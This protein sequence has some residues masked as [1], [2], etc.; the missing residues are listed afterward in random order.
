MSTASQAGFA[1]SEASGMSKTT[2]QDFPQ[3]P[4]DDVHAHAATVYI[5]GVEARWAARGLLV[6]ANGGTPAAAKAIVDIDLSE[7]PELPAGH[8]D[9][10]RRIETRIKIKTQNH[11]NAEKR[12]QVVLDAWTALYTDLKISTE[13]NAPVLSRELKDTCDLTSVG[14]DGSFDGPRAWRI[15]K[16]YLAGAS[17]TETDKDFY[18]TAERIQRSS[19]LPDG[20]TAADYSKK[21]LAFLIHILPNL[22]QSYDKDDTTTYLVN[23]MPKTLREGGRRIKNE[24]KA[25]KR[26]HDFMYVIRKCH[27]LVHEEQKTASAAPAFVITDLDAVHDL[28][29]LSSTTGMFLSLTPALAA[30]QGFQAAGSARGLGGPAGKKW[31]PDC[32]HGANGTCF[33]APGYEGPLP[34]NVFLNKE[35]LAGIV[36]AK[37][38]NARESGETLKPLRDPSR[39]AIDDFKKRRNERREAAKARDQAKKDKDKPALPALPAPAGAAVSGDEFADWRASLLDISENAELVGVD[40]DATGLLD[41]ADFDGVFMMAGTD[42]GDE[43]LADIDDDEDDGTPQFWFVLMPLAD[44]CVPCIV[45]LTD[46]SHVERDHDMTA[47]SPVAFGSDEAMARKVFALAARGEPPA[48]APALPVTA[49]VVPTRDVALGGSTGA[50]ARA[51]ILG[52]PLGPTP[53]P[54]GS[55]GPASTAS[56]VSTA[57]SVAPTVS[58]LATASARPPASPLP[59]GAPGAVTTPA[60]VAPA[61]PATSPRPPPPSG[62]PPPPTAAAGSHGLCGSCT[63][64]ADGYSPFSALG[65]RARRTVEDAPVDDSPRPAALHVGTSLA[66]FFG[67]LALCLTLRLGCNVDMSACAGLATGLA[68]AVGHDYAAEHGWWDGLTADALAESALAVAARAARGFASFSAHAW[69]VGVPHVLQHSRQ[70]LVLVIVVLFLRGIRGSAQGGVSTRSTRIRSAAIAPCR[71]SLVGPCPSPPPS[72]PQ[73]RLPTSADQLKPP[74]QDYL[75]HAQAEQLRVEL[76]A[77][78]E[79]PPNLPRSITHTIAI[80][81]TGCARSMANHKDQ[82]K[83]GSI[84]SFESEVTGVAGALKTKERGHMAFP[85]LTHNKGMRVWNEKQSIL[86]EVCAYVLLSLGRASLEQGMDLVM[87]AWGKDCT[88]SWPNG[89]IV[90]LLNR[91]V[92]V[93]RPLGYKESPSKGLTACFS[94]DALAVPD[95]Q[96]FCIYLGSGPRRHDD[97]TNQCLHLEAPVEMVLWDPIID[98]SHDATKVEFKDAALASIASSERRRCRGIIVSTRCHTWSVAGFLPDAHGNPGKPWRD[99]DHFFGIPRDGAIPQVV[100]DANNESSHAAEICLAVAEQGGFVIVESPARRT[101][102]KAHPGHVLADCS[103][104]VHMFDHPAWKRFI[105]RTD[106]TELLWDQCTKAAIPSESAVKSTLWLCTPDMVQFLEAEFGKV[107]SSLCNHPPGTHKPLRGVDEQGR[108][109]TSSSK[110]ENYSGGTNLSLARAIK[111]RL[112][113]NLGELAAVAGVTQG[114]V[115]ARHAVTHQFIHDSFNHSEARTL[116]LL[117]HALCDV[118]DWWSP[119][120][121]EMPCEA[122]LRGDS[123]RIGP[124]GHLPDDEGLMFLDIH[125]V[126]LPEIFTGQT[127][128]VG[129]THARTGFCKSARVNGKGDAHLAIELFLSLFNALGRAITWIHCDNANELKG[130]KVVTICRAHSIRITTTTVN[131]S[132]KN[133]QEPQWRAQMAV[134][135]K[136]LERAKAPYNFWGWA[137]DDAEEGR[138]L[139]PSREPPHDCSLGR[140]LS[141]VDKVVKPA[142]SYRRPFMC[143]CY[144][145]DAPRLP[146]GT[147]V[148]KLAAQSKRALNLGYVGGRGGS[149]ERVG[150]EHTQAG[151]ACYVAEENRIVVSSDVRH[152]PSCFPGLRRTS[153]GGWCIPDDSIPFVAEQ[154]PAAKVQKQQEKLLELETE[155]DVPSQGPADESLE[156]IRGFPPEPE[157]PD[158]AASRGGDAEKD[159]P[160]RGGQ[161]DAKPPPPP[162]ARYM[163]PREHWPNYHCEE[164][165]GKGWEVSVVKRQRDWSLCRFVR[166]K[167]QDGRAY[168]NEWRKTK[169]LIKLPDEE[170]QSPDLVQPNRPEEAVL[171]P[172]PAPRV[173]SPTKLPADEP[174]SP[175]ADARTNQRQPSAHEPTRLQF[176]QP[177]PNE[178]VAPP[179]GSS[180]QYRDPVRPE[181]P[182]KPPDRLGYAS[183]ALG[184]LHAD[185]AALGFDLRS[186]LLPEAAFLVDVSSGA[187]RLVAEARNLTESR[188]A[189][190]AVVEEQVLSHEF[191]V[192]A[193]EM[194]RAIMI[195]ADVTDTIVEFGYSS[196][197]TT[198][199]RELYAVAAF[200]AA[201]HGVLVP[202]LEPTVRIVSGH[203]SADVISADRLFD[204]EFD[205]CICHSGDPLLGD[206]LFALSKAKNSPDIFSERQMR[207]PEWDEPKLKEIAKIERLGAK[208]DVAADD[209]SIKGM[210]I[211]EMLW[212]GRCKRNED[213]SIKSLN[214]RC[215]AR[216]DLDKG[217]FNLTSNETTAPVARNSSNLA[218]DAVGVLRGMHKKDYDVPGAY[219]QGEQL[220]HEQRVY[221]P[222]PGFRKFDERGVEILWLSNNPFYGQTDAGAIWNRTIN[223]TLTTE[224][225]PDGC[226]LER[227]TQDPSLYACNELGECEL[228]G[229][230]N[231][232]LYVDDGRLAWDDGEPAAAK[233]KEIQK[234]LHDKYGIEFG[235]DD[236]PSTHFLGANI[237]TDKSR[238]VASVRATTYIDL[239]VKRYADGDVSASKRFPAHWSH[240]PADETLVRAWEAAMATRTPASPQLT[241]DYQSL[242][243]A[244]LHAVKFRPEIA[245]ALQLCGGCLTFPTEELY[246]CLMHILVYLGRSRNLGCTFSAHVPEATKLKAFADSNWAITRSV[247]GFVIMLAGAC[248]TA[249]SRRQHCITM[250]SCEAELVALADVAIEL[251]HIIEVV[252]FLGHDVVEPIEVSTDSKAAFDLCH[253]FT[254]AQ[255]SRH[256]DRKTFKMRE[257]RGAGRVVV[258]H[259]PGET[260][261]ADIFTKIL[262]RQPFEKHRKTVLNLPGDTGMEHARRLAVSA[263]RGAPSLRDGTGAP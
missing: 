60:P 102:P 12:K 42:A 183:L 100:I 197:Q 166:A 114:K 184:A 228:G 245:A 41:G 85:M 25:E 54:T 206:E 179:L 209:P 2:P 222:P 50:Q 239:M 192:A 53:L 3:C 125:H 145:T 190:F 57:V 130:T 26:E 69:R 249:V 23:L 95:D 75:D 58:A 88:V 167:D 51:S 241:Q 15:T 142:G 247:T 124:S 147:L 8:R 238:R 152:V 149:F 93:L 13:A 172:E 156:L 226:G 202:P 64:P 260:N 207:S 160:G 164:L 104:A 169:D 47:Y 240:A 252:R 251:L 234:K 218:F 111:S 217:K 92:L 159:A 223:T 40:G 200:D 72:P 106:A 11:S 263:S 62:P 70:Y 243:G 67:F 49:A 214:A 161:A 7:L 84:Y 39:K 230:V 139:M 244:E 168:P 65:R 186:P 225:V 165:E 227:C 61:L 254:S 221:R 216:G 68:T 43:P 193:F 171:P 87:P 262:T 198:F 141:S 205:G 46:E 123:K 30:A 126:T 99:S 103:K 119:I 203:M 155:D 259:I 170:P 153:R 131:S 235:E 219:L 28:S 32:P 20:C 56:G 101:G 187:D 255:N 78:H 14:Y 211:C 135:R 17:R 29:K 132:R 35:R 178:H 151:Y 224:R 1:A 94:A 33:T 173:H 133:R 86:N 150:I 128:T 74:R 196:P 188:G 48:A 80:A 175:Q 185:V 10:N 194:Q 208:T 220:A 89:V 121:V 107:P 212:T 98:G 109:V 44:G 163:V 63:S 144:V 5:E 90:K 246:D 116:K 250:S 261:P 113:L 229:Q 129:C 96:D 31:C 191:E 97:L 79:V 37:A 55:A 105:E 117:H 237:L 137:W 120:I 177:V 4:G 24:L 134:V 66:V 199:M 122:C 112:E 162:P 233:A 215:C 204:A 176:D 18:R 138:S 81:D 158:D 22:P 195:S 181:R 174:E 16:H 248:I 180:D 118:P 77:G 232:T 115:L 19:I 76:L 59:T 110:S 201:A 82:M 34:V 154:E 91:N 210:Q 236:P 45:C 9:Y 253:R 38:A 73:A 258:R 127:T 6:V 189:A 71:A 213:T 242:F 143:L 52:D 148:N 182:R 231:N 157:A 83:P 108:Y 146:S 27:D 21:A 140:L 36:A 257:L 256:I 136:L